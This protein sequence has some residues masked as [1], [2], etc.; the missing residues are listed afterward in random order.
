MLEEKEAQKIIGRHANETT[1]ARQNKTTRGTQKIGSTQINWWYA[2]ETMVTRKKRNYW[3]H[4]KNWRPEN[5]TT[6][7]KKTTAGT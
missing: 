4:A 7:S 5:K 3:R 1:A 2:K 6:G